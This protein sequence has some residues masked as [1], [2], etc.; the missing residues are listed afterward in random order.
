[1]S[2]WEN[3]SV[4]SEDGTFIFPLL[5]HPDN[6]GMAHVMG[7]VDRFVGW[8]RRWGDSVEFHTID[9]CEFYYV[10]AGLDAKNLSEANAVVLREGCQGLAKECL[11]RVP[12]A[13]R[14]NFEVLANTLRSSFPYEEEEVN[15]NTILN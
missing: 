15:D 7:M 11:K 9:K 14:K 3:S 10:N 8:L 1:M 6:S 5:M 2:M 4:D 12:R 13:D